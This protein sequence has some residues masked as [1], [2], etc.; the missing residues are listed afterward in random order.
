[1]QAPVLQVDLPHSAMCRKGQQ[2]HSSYLVYSEHVKVS[3][4]ILVCILNSCHTLLFIDQL[5]NI[6][7]NKFS[8]EIRRI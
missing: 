8:L 1:M 6:L 3:D 2:S 5:T 4:V 7:I